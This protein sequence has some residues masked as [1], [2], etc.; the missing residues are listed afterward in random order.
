LSQAGSG[1]DHAEDKVSLPAR[2]K[3]LKLKAKDEGF[4]FLATF[5]RVDLEGWY[6]TS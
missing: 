6:S 4:D 2:A 1:V 5:E 3:E